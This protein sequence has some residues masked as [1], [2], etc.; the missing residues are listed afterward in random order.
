MRC[1]A[2]DYPTNEACDE[3]MQDNTNNADLPC[4]SLRDVVISLLLQETKG[5]K[6]VV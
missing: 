2:E 6:E 4:S 1:M 3:K 5:E